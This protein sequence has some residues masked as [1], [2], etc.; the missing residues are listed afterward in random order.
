M[1][2]F[3]ERHRYSAVHLKMAQL[4]GGVLLLIRNVIES[5]VP[6]YPAALRR[7][8]RRELPALRTQALR[9]ALEVL[10]AEAQ[11]LRFAEAVLRPDFPLMARV[12]FGIVD[13]LCH[14]IPPKL[15][16]AIRDAIN[17][18]ARGDFDDGRQLMFA[19]ATRRN[20]PEAALCRFVLWQAIRM[21]VFVMTWD[22]PLVE[23]S[24]VLAEVEADAENWLR[25]ALEVPDMF[26]EDVRPLHVLVAEASFRITE[27]VT[28]GISAEFAAELIQTVE[29]LHA[30][31]A[32]YAADVAALW[33]GA[34]NGPLGSQQVADRYPQHFSNANNVD[35]RR[36]RARRKKSRR[37]AGDRLVDLLRDLSLPENAP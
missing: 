12:H 9:L 19:I 1:S 7:Q 8:I 36:S 6:F 29:D 27:S 35:Q 4:G 13:A 25:S 21:N 11:E 23:V 26:D 15:R 2:G 24:G 17:A 32:M 37:P 22:E 20:D 5:V 18:A 31:R 34:A 3:D 30:V 14:R 28:A 33:P 16:N 10:D